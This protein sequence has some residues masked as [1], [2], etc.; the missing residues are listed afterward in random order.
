FKVGKSSPRLGLPSHTFNDGQHI[1]SKYETIIFNSCKRPAV[2]KPLQCLG[3]RY[4]HPKSAAKIDRILR[5]EGKA[6]LFLRRNHGRL[7]AHPVKHRYP[8]THTFEKL[9]RNYRLE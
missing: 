9:R 5:F 3:L 4:K 1:L 6:N 7:A 8:H 2:A